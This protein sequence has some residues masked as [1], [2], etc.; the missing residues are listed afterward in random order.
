MEPHVVAG[1]LVRAEVCFTPDASHDDDIDKAYHDK[2]GH[3]DPVRAITS[4]QARATT[5]R[6]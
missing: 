5:L 2:Y 4:P 1:P 6:I 3:G